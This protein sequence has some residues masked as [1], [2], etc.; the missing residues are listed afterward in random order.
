[1]SLL[2]ERFMRAMRAMNRLNRMRRARKQNERQRNLGRV[3]DGDGGDFSYERNYEKWETDKG[4][5]KKK[6]SGF[7]RTLFYGF[8]P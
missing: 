8:N 1:M 3:R 6:K 7:I 5:P 4:G 2:N